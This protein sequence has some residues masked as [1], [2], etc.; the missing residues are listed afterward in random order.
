MNKQKF[1]SIA[2]LV[3]GIVLI[4][5][6]LFSTGFYIS[7]VFESI[8]IADKSAIFW[9][10]PFLMIGFIIVVVG[11]FFS[12]VGYRS[13]RGDERA[14]KESKYMMI[15]ILI[16]ILLLIIVAAYNSMIS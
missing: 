10:I 4:I 14:V 15:S 16:L 12:L 2:T 1:I 11:F 3:S 13:L 7:A 9:F 6:G 5:S 8:Y